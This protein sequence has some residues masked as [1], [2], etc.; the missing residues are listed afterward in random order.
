MGLL[1]CMVPQPQ[2]VEEVPYLVWSKLCEHG[3]NLLAALAFVSLCISAYLRRKMNNEIGGLLVLHVP[4]L[5]CFEKNHE[6]GYPSG[7]PHM[8]SCSVSLLIFPTVLFLASC[9][10]GISTVLIPTYL[11]YTGPQF[12]EDSKHQFNYHR[13]DG[14]YVL[15]WCIAGGSAGII[16][17]QRHEG[18]GDYYSTHF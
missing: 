5:F 9:F 6:Q 17:K 16:I 8:H 14:S 13:Y 4:L 1:I 2:L 12:W 3:N 7:I 10:I 18:A 11:S 15:C